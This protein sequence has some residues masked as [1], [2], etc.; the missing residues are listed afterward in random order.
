MPRFC[1]CDPAITAQL[2]HWTLNKKFKFKFKGC[3]TQFLGSVLQNFDHQLIILW[4]SYDRVW[5]CKFHVNKIYLAKQIR[6]SRE[7]W[8]KTFKNESSIAVFIIRVILYVS[9]EKC[10]PSIL[11]FCFCLF[12]S[13]FVFNLV[14]YFS[15]FASLCLICSFTNPFES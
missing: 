3:F 12:V 10:L 1:F 9:R 8:L 5:L 2:V 7:N 15:N 14:F 13:L 11:L 4:P 6:Q